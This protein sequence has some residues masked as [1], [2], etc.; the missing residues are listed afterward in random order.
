MILL[1]ST[2]ALA[3]AQNPY[4]GGEVTQIEID[5][6]GSFI[7]TA[8]NAGVTYEINGTPGS[9]GTVTTTLYN[10]NPQATAEIPDGVALTK[11]VVVTF[12][13]NSEDFMQATL[14]FSYSDADVAGLQGPFAVYKYIPETNSFVQLEGELDTTAKTIT[15]TL[16][17][18]VDPLFAIGGSNTSSVTEDVQTT[19]WIVVAIAVIV[20]VLVMFIFIKRRYSE[21][22]HQK[23]NGYWRPGI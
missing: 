21:D 5:N 15:I 20:I 10:G 8:S 19:L 22:M 13:F 11:F 9:T 16:N 6:S 18:T 4:P 17:S 12:D 14:T 23:P 3:V 7:A 2:S 1:I